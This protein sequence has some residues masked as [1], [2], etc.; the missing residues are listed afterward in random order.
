M[1]IEIY[2]ACSSFFIFGDIIGLIFYRDVSYGN[3][4]QNGYQYKKC[5]IIDVLYS[6]DR[7]YNNLLQFEILIDHPLSILKN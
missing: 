1:E 2:S 7:L 3:H 6:L 5:K 4:N